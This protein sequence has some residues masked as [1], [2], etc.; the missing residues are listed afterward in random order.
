MS[1]ETS[2]IANNRPISVYGLSDPRAGE[3]RYVGVTK[4][5]LS[6][7]YSKHLRDQSNNHKAAWVKS[8]KK[9]G[10][11]P[12][13]HILE[14]CRR[15][16]K[17]EE[18]AWIRKLK[19]EGHRLVNLTAGGDGCHEWHPNEATRLRMRLSHLGHKPPPRIGFHHTEEVKA[20]I[21]R[22]MKGRKPPNYAIFIKQA[23]QVGKRHSEETRA[24]LRA[25]WVRRR[26]RPPSI[27]D[28]SA[29]AQR[30]W[31]TRRAKGAA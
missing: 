17:S 16:G 4:Q 13:L 8:L 6:H 3:I 5:K 24:K 15:D 10:L 30:A 19:S 7:R 26:L 28:R 1:T 27:Y 23:L 11:V 21:S 20:R 2:L 31:N 22:T 25:A 9:N 29:S 12:Q 18:M 14:I